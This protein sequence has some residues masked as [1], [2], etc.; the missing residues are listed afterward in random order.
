MKRKILTAAVVVIST[1]AQAEDILIR[2][3][4]ACTLPEG[5]NFAPFDPLYNPNGMGEFCVFPFLPLK[6]AV[7]AELERVRELTGP[8]GLP[9]C[10]KLSVSPGAVTLPCY[11]V[12][13]E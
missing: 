4:A 9:E 7:T 8:E 13:T 3:G 11:E 6:E 5:S 10:E 1:F 2:D 12:I